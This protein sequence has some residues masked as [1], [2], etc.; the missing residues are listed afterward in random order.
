MARLNSGTR[1]YG[2][3]TIDTFA[4]ISGNLN[5]VGGNV[6]IASGG[7]VTA[8]TRIQAG[9]PYTSFPTIAISAPTTIGGVQATAS[10]TGM[11]FYGSTPQTIN[12]AGSGYTVGNLLT[13]VGGTG[14][15]CT[16]TVTAIDGSGGVT[17]ATHTNF[18]NYTV[19]PSVPYSVT[20]GSGTGATFTS[21]WQVNGQSI[22]N[23]GSGYVA[24]PTVTFSGG[25]AVTQA[26]AFATV[27]GIPKVQ[28]LGNSLSVYTPSGEQMR[29]ADR[30]GVSPTTTRYVQ[31]SGGVNGV[32]APSVGTGGGSE[33]FDIYSSGGFGIYLATNGTRTAL[34]AVISHT[35]SA[36]NYVQLT[37]STANNGVTIS[38][39]GT[40][41]NLDVIITPKGTGN[42]ASTGNVSA[43]GNIAA[44]N[45]STSNTI[46]AFNNM[47]INSNGVEG[48]QLIMAWANTSGITGQANSTWNIDVDTGN[49]FRVFYQNAA[50]ATNILVNASPT[51]NVVTFTNVIKTATTVFASLPAA[52]TAGAG[53]RAFITDATAATFG[54]VAAGGGANAVPVWSDGT[55][56][57]IG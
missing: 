25:G 15:P 33:A 26:T 17:A 24:Q 46:S 19:L 53:A 29:I 8:L 3:A 52:A 2:N 42:L 10:V 21:G 22:S 4:T 32:T 41:T 49:N 34:Q 31:V 56:W 36:V 9:G 54:T 14:T 11:T 30:S 47:I 50:G 13:I 27:G 48:G 12:S 38:A 57:K 6:N 18:N 1:I 20:G 45:I 44:N 7:T 51:T 39:Q 40:G 35:P 23:A 28:A 5:T 55:N 37:G 16:L 43:A